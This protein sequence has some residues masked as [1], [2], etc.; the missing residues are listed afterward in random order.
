MHTPRKARYAFLAVAPLVLWAAVQPAP[1]PAHCDADTDI[2]AGEAH[3]ALW[4]ALGGRL[5]FEREGGPF[6]RLTFR[7]DPDYLRFDQDASLRVR[8]EPSCR[9]GDHLLALDFDMRFSHELQGEAELADVMLLGAKAW[10]LPGAG[11]PEKNRWVHVRMPLPPG[12]ADFDAVHWGA[13]AAW[14]R[15]RPGEAITM[16][17]RNVVV[18]RAVFSHAVVPGLPGPGGAAR[19]RDPDDPA[20]P[21]PRPVVSVAAGAPAWAVVDF[22]GRTPGALHLAAGA[23]AVELWHAEWRDVETKPGV[24]GREA[25]R[26]L[27]YRGSSLRAG[28]EPH[29]FWLRIASRPATPARVHEVR[30]QLGPLSVTYAVDV[31]AGRVPAAAAAFVMYYQMNRSWPAWAAHARFFEDAPAHFSQLAALGFTGLHLAEDPVFDFDGKRVVANLESSARRWQN[32]P[33][34]PAEVIDAARAAALTRPLVWEGLRI[35]GRDDV[36]AAIAHAC[37]VMPDAG[38]GRFALLAATAG[39]L[40]KER[41]GALPYFSIADEPGTESDAAVERVGRGLKSL[42][43]AGFPTYLTTHARLYDSFHKLAPW[44]DVNALHA[45]DVTAGAAAFVRARGGRLWLYN[46][47]SFNTAPP[48]HDRFF[49]GLYAWLAGADGVAQWIYSRPSELSDALD[50]RSRLRDDAQFYALPGEGDE[51]A[52]TPGLLGLAAGITDRALL[53]AAAGTPAG[54]AVLARLRAEFTLPSE[55]SEYTPSTLQRRVD[56]HGIRRQLL[57]ALRSGVSQ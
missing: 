42:H 49:A 11:V 14:A 34:P 19:R 54:R 18:R 13:G 16:D 46:G 26:L 33:A 17:I 56:M 20:L 5:T 12:A 24:V 52:A 48:G 37:D 21:D 29:R 10:M 1:D 27:P 7:A 22:P 32:W 55:P 45:E 9:A 51:P 30:L 6:V 36:W 47:G 38:D 15:E 41:A 53:D 25:I 35:Y 23:L 44:L 8:V 39:P 4:S 31:F 40:W 28:D 3:A 50:L 43:A 2:P 57:S